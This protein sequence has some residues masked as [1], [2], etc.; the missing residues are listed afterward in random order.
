VTQS[1]FLVVV[2]SCLESTVILIYYQRLQASNSLSVFEGSGE[3]RTH[4]SNHRADMPSLS[5]TCGEGTT[6]VSQAS[7]HVFCQHLSSNYSKDGHRVRGCEP[8]CLAETGRLF[9]ICSAVS[10]TLEVSLS[11]ITLLKEHW[12]GFYGRSRST[13]IAQFE[14]LIKAGVF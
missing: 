14:V 6:A 12:F 13:Q 1:S 8:A 11:L 2:R 4:K 10:K 3:T 7:F 5:Y 9:C